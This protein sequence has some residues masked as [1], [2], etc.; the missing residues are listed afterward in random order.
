[1]IRCPVCGEALEQ[2]II[3]GVTIDVCSQHGAWLDQGELVM[4]TEAERHK[5]GRFALSD[6][7]RTVMQPPVDASR[8]LDC[9]Q[10]GKDMT[11]E[12][13]QD[14]H[15]DR[16]PDHGIW[17]DTGELTALLNNLRLDHRYRRGTSARIWEARF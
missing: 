6:L 1:M 11:L 16:C 9:P 7:L 8:V 10:C 15:L 4:L 14:V 2:T 3:H 12:R 5:V 13:Y 17:L